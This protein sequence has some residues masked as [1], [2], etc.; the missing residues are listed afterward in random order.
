M[1]KYSTRSA[2][3]KMRALNLKL[4]FSIAL[5]F[6]LFAFQWEIKERPVKK[7]NNIID[8]ESIDVTQ[9]IPRIK[10]KKIV[11]PPPLE[12]KSIISKN[13]I[14]T[15]FEI[16]QVNDEIDD[17]PE[18]LIDE[19]VFEG[20]GFDNGETIAESK[21]EITTSKEEDEIFV[22]AQKMPLFGD[23]DSSNRTERKACSD[24]A[25]LE[26]IY[27]HINYPTLARE[28]AIE[29][30][31]VA[32]LVITKEG[33]VEQVKIVRELGGGCSQ[34]VLR[35]LENMPDWIPGMNNFKAVRVKMTVPVKFVLQ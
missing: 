31:V 1:K 25:I 28:N 11:P 35:V 15:D 21:I 9:D 24:K 18:D 4:G 6:V 20:V 34:E 27:D 17:D 12:V 29:G 7:H 23:C 2:W 26:Y 32:T 13:I 19:N 16:E 33:K 10:F 8:I 5:V 30:F 3:S 14:L 22:I